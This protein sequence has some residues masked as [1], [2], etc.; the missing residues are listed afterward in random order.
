MHPNGDG[1]RCP[2]CGNPGSRGLYEASDPRFDLPGRFKVMGCAN[3]GN[4]WTAPRPSASELR[5]HYPDTYDPYRPDL[6]ERSRSAVHRAFLGAGLRFGAAATDAFP[7]GSLLDVGCGNGAYMAS[8]AMRGYT[9][10][11]IDV[12]PRACELV[13]RRG[14]R[15]LEGDFLEIALEPE[16]FDIVTMNHF[17]EHSLEPRASLR[18]A[19]AVLRPGG[20]L[21][22]GVPNFDSWA[23]RRF[24]A[25]WSDLELPRHLTHFTPRGL[26]RLL[27]ECGFAE[28]RVRYDP[29]A[30]AGSILTSL[31]VRTRKRDDPVLHAVYPALHAA[32]YPIGMP[33]SFLGR[34]AWM[35]VTASKAGR[36]RA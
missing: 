31:L 30:D 8:M 1:A 26:T 15:V 29:S 16:S 14:L 34:S 22:V 6:S 20:W 17:L 9:V 23:R 5:Q 2:L 3:C 7:V 24:G 25:N 33:L 10:T 28:P 36:P 13:A 18:K 12:N 35:R 19:H 4:A 11:G 21:V 32:L 27:E